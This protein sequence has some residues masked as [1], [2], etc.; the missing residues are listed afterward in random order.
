MP[1]RITNISVTVYRDGKRKALLP[2][3][4]FN[5]TDEEIKDIEGAHRGSLRK[6]NSEMDDVLDLTTMDGN[7]TA[8]PKKEEAD[9]VD[10]KSKA[11]TP[12]EKKAQ[13]K[14]QEN[15][16]TADENA[17]AEDEGL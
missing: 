3:T 9:V 13:K 12:A 7:T 5:F 1:Q 4:K 8:E 11:L 15:A 16:K 2:N 14:A 17:S 10:T 6:P